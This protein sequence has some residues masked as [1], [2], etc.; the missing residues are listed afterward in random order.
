MARNSNNASKIKLSWGKEESRLMSCLLYKGLR[1]HYRELLYVCLFS[2]VHAK[3]WK[4]L[5]TL[6]HWHSSWSLGINGQACE[7]E[8]E[9][10]GTW[11]LSQCWQRFEHHRQL[12][13]VGWCLPDK[14]DPSGSSRQWQCC[15]SRSSFSEVFKAGWAWLQKEPVHRVLEP[16]VWRDFKRNI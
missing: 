10:G 9:R 15:R 7:C 14:S 12:G 1:V 4:L 3:F 11:V 13:R 6:S 8:V 2:T 16:L 5:L